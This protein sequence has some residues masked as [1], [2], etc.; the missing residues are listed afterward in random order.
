MKSII[1]AISLLTASCQAG[2]PAEGADH[3]TADNRLTDRERTDGW[4]LL[5]DGR[6]L[7]GWTTSSQQPSK[8]PIDD[9]AIN[10]HGCGGYMMIHEKTWGDFVL[11][12]DFKIAKGCN[13]GVFVRTFP[14]MPRPG[15]DVGYNGI[16]V[17]VDDT[18]DAGYHDTGALYDL[19]KPA[20]NAMKPAGQ[21]NH[22]VVTCDKNEIAVVLNGTT[23][24]QLDLDQWTEKNKRPD[25][26][27][28]K[29]DTAF[30]EH[31]RAGYIG[32]QDHGGECWYKNIK[33]KPLR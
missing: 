3:S 7:D 16:E 6:S 12:L 18:T 23:V 25:G 9:G 1:L 26:S 20:R 15:K 24:S 17:A 13:S 31:P 28:H 4:V 5:F 30:A 14:L 33:L 29:F 22:L 11:S 19:V 27:P 32:L 2:D 21:W 10:P 8:R